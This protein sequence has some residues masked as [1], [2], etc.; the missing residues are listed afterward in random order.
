MENPASSITSG[1][2]GGV[3]VWIWVAVAIVIFLALSQHTAAAA[4]S[5][6]SADATGASSSS[7]QLAAA[8]LAAKSQFALAAI[9]VAGAEDIARI[10]ARS[11]E[12]ANDTE[13]AAFIAQQQA[14]VDTTA[15]QNQQP[16]TIVVNKGNTGNTAQSN[17]F[18]KS[19]ALAAQRV[20]ATRMNLL[21]SVG[22]AIADGVH[23]ATAAHL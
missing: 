17:A 22:G 19:S 8:Q 7:D 16:V 23:Y 2:K 12:Q 9:Q 18:S 10:N 21:N 3:P 15:A 4:Q 11:T 6:T 13:L 1:A 5:P 14:T 20:R